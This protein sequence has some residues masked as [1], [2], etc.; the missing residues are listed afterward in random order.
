M[1]ELRRRAVPHKVLV[2]GKGP[3]RGRF[4]ER[5]PEACFTGMLTGPELGRAVAS[6]DLLL[7]PSV[8]ETFG[9]V[10][11]E[12]M[13]SG[14][15]VLA[16]R[17]TG[18]NS[19]VTE[20]VTGHLVEPSNIAGFADAIARYVAEPALREAHGAAGERRSRAFAWDAINHAVAEVYL[21]LVTGQAPPQCNTPAAVIR[22]A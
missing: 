17:A 9:N 12:A 4:A 13:A 11:L 7:N 5:V 19:L 15:P 22:R 21:R 2:I 10:T 16:A 6:M 18:S 3:A 14:V 1:E 20:G 8:T